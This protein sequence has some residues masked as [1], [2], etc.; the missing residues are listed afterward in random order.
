MALYRMPIPMKITYSFPKMLECASMA[1]NW[2]VGP[3][4]EKRLPRGNQGKMIFIRFEEC[5][6]SA[7]KLN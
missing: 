5:V 2:E 1:N 4:K 3:Y 6:F 7:K